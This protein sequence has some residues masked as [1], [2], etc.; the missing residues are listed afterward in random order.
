LEKAFEVHLSI[1]NISNCKDSGKKVKYT[2]W[3]HLPYRLGTFAARM[4]TF[5]EGN[6]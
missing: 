5:A 3:V 6:N 1:D 2:E 4:G